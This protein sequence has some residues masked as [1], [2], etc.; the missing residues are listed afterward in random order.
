[1]SLHNFRYLCCDWC[2]VSPHFSMVKGGDFLAFFVAFM[3]VVG[4]SDLI[5]WEYVI[6][7]VQCDPQNQ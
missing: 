2:S 6:S 3:R 1:M 7:I 4:L 5:S